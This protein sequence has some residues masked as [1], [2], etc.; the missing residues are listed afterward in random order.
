MTERLNV[1]AQQANLSPDEKQKVAALSKLVDQHKSLLDMPAVQ[2]QQKFFTLPQDQQDSLVTFMGNDPVE[3][4]RSPLGTAAHY[5]GAGLKRGL[6]ALNEASD[7]MTRLY[8]AY[9]LASEKGVGSLTTNPFKQPKKIVEA[10]QESNDK[11]ELLYNKARIND[12][13]TKYGPD[14]VWIA[15]KVTEKTPWA[16]IQAQATTDAQKR[17]VADISAGKN[18][19]FQDAY[20]AVFASKYSPGRQLANQVLPEALEGSGP[21][22]KAI[23]GSTDAA[24]R[25]FADPTLFLGKAKKAYEVANYAIVKV[26]GNAQKID[27][28]FS[29][30]AVTRFF[31]TYGSELEKLAQARKADK[32]L[33]AAAASTNLKRLAPEFGP[34]AVD[35]LIRAGVKNSDTAKAYL[36]NSADVQAVLLGQSARRTPLIPRLD[37]RRQARIAYYTATNKLFNI[38]E[39][40]QKVVQSLYGTSPQY[41]DIITG[42]TKSEDAA[43]LEQQV[44]RIKKIKGSDGALRMPLSQIQGR[45]DRFA[46]KFTTTPFFKDGVFDVMAADAPTKIYQ[47]ARIANT[48]Y[49]SKIIAEAFAAGGEGQRKD[50]VTG[51]WN[52]IAEIRGVSK[53]SAGRTYMQEFAGRGV[54]K[55][56]APDIVIDGIVKGNPAEFAGEQMALFP[57][58]LSSSMV[59]P[60]V[61]DLDRLSARSGIINKIVGLSHQKWAERLTNGWSFL[62]LA[63]PRFVLRNATEDV[64]FTLANGSNTWGLIKGRNLS[65]L[66]RIAKAQGGDLTALQKLKKS[67]LLD[68][69]SGELGAINKFVKAGKMK[70]YAEKV[71]N[72][73]SY[74][75]VRNIFAE[76]VLE[77]N[78]PF[79]IGAKESRYVSEWVKHGHIDD[80]F[81]DVT[82]GAKNAMTATGSYGALTNDVSKFGKM[83]VLQID[84][85]KYRRST[86]DK[87]FTQFNPTANQQAKVSWMFQIGVMASDDIGKI[88]IRN[89]ENEAAA[90]AAIKD[91]LLKLPKEDLDKFRLYTSGGTVENH[92]Y[93]A[94]AAAKNLFVKKDGKTLN[95]ALVDKVR[96]YNPKGEIVVNSK[97][98]SIHDLPTSPAD[99]PEYISGPTLVPVS[100][101]DNFAGSIFDKGW[102]A[103]GEANARWSREPIVIR[104]YNKY[105]QQ[106]ENSGLE[107]RIIESF[108]AGLKG[109]EYKR[110]YDRAMQH[111]VSLAEDMAKD[112]TLAYIDNPAVRSQLAMA[113]RN[114]G[115]FYR[116]TEDFYRRL[117]R[118]VRYNPE[119][120]ARASLTYEG[121]AHSGFIQ[122][123]ENGE[124]YFFYPGVNQVYKAV[125]GILGAFGLEGS[126]KI[127]LPVQFSA[128][129]KMI[130]P[131]FNPDSLFPT[132]SGPIS[133]ISMKAVFAL[134]PALDKYEK[135]LLGTY[136]EDQ[137]VI[138]AI[139]PAHI[140]RLIA[141][142]DRN[143]RNSQY[144][145]GFRKAATYAVAAGLAPK[146]ELN[147][148]TGNIEISLGALKKFKDIIGVATLNVL[149]TRFALG[150]FVPASPQVT[151]K[152]DMAKWVRDNGAVSWK[153][154][155]TAMLKQ[156]GGDYQKA[157]GEWIKYYPDQLAYTVSESESPAVAFV[158]SSKAA[159][160]WVAKNKKL[161]SDYPQAAMFFLPDSGDFDFTT[162]KLMLSSKIK[163]SKTITDFL[164]QVE[165]AKD[166]SIYYQKVDE[167]NA[168]LA[169][170]F[171]PYSKSKLKD[172]F[173]TWKKEYLGAR[174]ALREELV[175]NAQNANL[176]NDALRDLERLMADKQANLD[177]KIKESIQKMLTTYSDYVQKRDAM[178]G[179]GSSAS[180][181]KDIMKQNT[182]TELENISLTNRNARNLWYTLFSKLMRD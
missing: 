144:A 55:K 33:E 31:D 155:F 53:S 159:G 48:R 110:A 120:I 12:A 121:V 111:V 173:D 125:G 1:A 11:G 119:S 169:Q 37:A 147:K 28:V 51:L 89:I 100:T 75:E 136:S 162:Y 9:Q 88:A 106:M 22:Y 62:T 174:P 181:L 59:M 149:F 81:D 135:N 18:K 139:F 107:K 17:L 14:L 56:Y 30:P 79:D 129:L 97:R 10:W 27:E 25:W 180:Y 104:E 92:A 170:S 131:S 102:D 117:G 133:A 151:L 13:T 103:M 74:E 177:P 35:E 64:L 178:I 134:V 43:R 45:L 8:R 7:F 90:V 83:A 29:K 26:A 69:A 112:S 39:V 20:D 166:E 179:S 70:Q 182:K 2:A 150:F 137:P 124:E 128:K 127:P 91:Y 32:P 158:N 141:L 132:F 160:Q 109:D 138:Q 167:Y 68:T 85:V 15:Q 19:L 175:K 163:E 142:M 171:D 67:L 47:L 3:T 86:G 52:T 6:G 140:N 157:I 5:I 148:N 176:R 58:Q 16:E 60:S 4:N 76:A 98:L 42:I 96:Y 46:R 78:L 99:A 156:N 44:G 49:H 108:T 122:K 34:A 21:L 172:E 113:G 36:Q 118:A 145:S 146:P 54:E 65:T 82:E 93:R 165:T 41:Q 168:K 143:E 126:N 80:V 164:R 161:I 123:D 101:S 95:K 115:R 87:A 50:I 130:T 71:N 152:S 105:R 114:F 72:A 63:G 38:D 154:A 94:F 116:A 40:G 66:Y 84:D 73:N 153:S 24:Y 77:S 57:Y 61:N 23:S